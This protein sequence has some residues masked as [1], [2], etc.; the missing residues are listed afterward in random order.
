MPSEPQ[1]AR[2]SSADPQRNGMVTNGDLGS[3][4]AIA[5]LLYMRHRAKLRAGGGAAE[6]AGGEGGSS[7]G[8][9]RGCEDDTH[10]I[11]PERHSELEGIHRNSKFEER[12]GINVTPDVYARKHPKRDREVGVEEAEGPKRPSDRGGCEWRGKGV[13]GDGEAGEA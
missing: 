11:A 10:K 4:R 13:Q 12:G 9:G 5:L 8:V 2:W 1:R 3:T 7:A 6:A